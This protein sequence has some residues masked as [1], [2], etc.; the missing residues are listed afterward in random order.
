[1]QIKC[2]PKQLNVIFLSMRKLQ[3]AFKVFGYC[4]SLFV[5]PY[6]CV[7]CCEYILIF[8]QVLFLFFVASFS[9]LVFAAHQSRIALHGNG[10]LRG[11]AGDAGLRHSKLNN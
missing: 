10:G 3:T 7:I 4:P 6:L 8:L 11:V 5:C 9:L 2:K 1:M